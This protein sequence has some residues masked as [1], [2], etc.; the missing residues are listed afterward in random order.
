MARI[1]IVGS[2]AVGTYT[3]A[4]FRGIGNEV[5]FYDSSRARIQA[6]SDLN[7]EATADLDLAV[8]DSDFSFICVP[9]PTKNGRIDLGYVKSAAEAVARSLREKHSYHVVVV[10]STVIPTSTEKVLV[11]ALAELSRRKIG[12]EVGVW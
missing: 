1:C 10:R 12:P 9:T 11:P 2:G 4:V 5:E 7:L 3:G 8:R 6:L